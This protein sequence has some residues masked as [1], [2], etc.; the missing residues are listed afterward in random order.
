MCFGFVVFVLCTQCCPQMTTTQVTYPDPCIASASVCNEPAKC[1]AVGPQDFICVCPETDKTRNDNCLIP[2][3]YEK[4]GSEK[5]DS[6]THLWDA[7]C[8]MHA[9]CLQGFVSHALS[10]TSQYG[11]VNPETQWQT[12]PRMFEVQFPPFLQDFICVCPETDKTRNDNCLIPHY[13]EK[14]GFCCAKNT[15]KGDAIVWP[16]F[17]V[18]CHTWGQFYSPCSLFFVTDGGN[19]I[20]LFLCSLK[21]S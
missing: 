8:K 18:L 1:K 3:Y 5:P 10:V 4:Y 6:Q 19:C 12:C 15:C 17:F 14:Y 21:S 2:H 7:P 16:L 9:P 20:V 11:P 13:Y